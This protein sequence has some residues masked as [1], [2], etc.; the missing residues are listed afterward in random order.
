[1]AAVANKTSL[2]LAIIMCVA[3]TNGELFFVSLFLLSVK[4]N[5][6]GQNQKAITILQDEITVSLANEYHQ[7]ICPGNLWI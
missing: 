2:L 3:G 6:V 4:A 1:L 5:I 7:M